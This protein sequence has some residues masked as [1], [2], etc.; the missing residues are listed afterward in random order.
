MFFNDTDR[1]DFLDRLAALVQ[2]GAAVREVGYSGADVARYLGVTNCCVTRFVASGKK[3]DVDDLIRK[4]GCPARTSIFPN[5]TWRRME[6]LSV[7]W[8]PPVRVYHP[9]PLVRFGV[10]T[11]GKSRMRQSLTY[12]SGER[13]TRLQ[14]SG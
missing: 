8:L 6:Y 3:P 4:L 1:S 5:V 14:S 11:R 10:I 2:E 12:G 13:P 9:Y 7:K